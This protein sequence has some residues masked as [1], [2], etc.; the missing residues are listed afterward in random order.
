MFLKAELDRKVLVAHFADFSINPFLAG[1]GRRHRR[2]HCSCTFTLA[3]LLFQ[4]LENIQKIELLLVNICL[5]VQRH[6][7]K[8][9]EL[10]WDQGW[11]SSVLEE[12]QG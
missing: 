3:G 8:A 6:R 4:S 9:G 12:P 10:D 1:I 7:A 2:G 11:D 5:K